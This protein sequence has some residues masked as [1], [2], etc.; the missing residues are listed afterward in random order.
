MSALTEATV[1]VEAGEKSGTL[2]Q[3]RAALNQGRKLFVLDGCFRNSRLSWP[4]KL[5]GK[6]PSESE[7]TMIS[8][9]TFPQRF[10]EVDDLTRQDHYYLTGDDA[11]YFIGEYTGRKGYAYSATN[12]LILNFKKPMDR[13]GRPEWRYKEQAIRQAADA[14]GAALGSDA[15]DRLTFVPIPPSK[16]KDDPLHD[17]RLTRMLRAIRPEPPLDVRELIVQTVSTEAVHASGVRPTPDQIE[18]FY[19][20]DEALTAPVRSFIAIVDDVLTTGAH[21]QAAKSILSIRFPEASVVGLFIA[22]PGCGAKAEDGGGF[23]VGGPDEVARAGQCR[24]TKVASDA[25][26]PEAATL[27]PKPERLRDPKPRRDERRPGSPAN[28]RAKSPRRFCRI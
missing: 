18:E 5:V 11:C 10:T 16:A 26:V 9:G 24:V 17:N 14:F 7:T 28:R 3:A 2:I 23:A 12:Q 27:V 19:E 4:D 6:G 15:L 8:N 25:L 1:I 13:H 22:L 20:I 21:F